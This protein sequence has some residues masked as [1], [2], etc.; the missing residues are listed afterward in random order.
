[1]SPFVKLADP[2][3]YVACPMDV[4]GDPAAREY[5]LPFF[6]SHF[7]LILGLAEE[8]LGPSHEIRRRMDEAAAAFDAKFDAFAENPQDFGRVTIMTLDGWRDAILR[9]FEFP[10]PFAAQ[11]ARENERSLAHLPAAV[12][13]V[14]AAAD[15]P[16]A[17]VEGV[18]AGNIFDMGAKETA[19]LYRDG[20]PNFDAVIER[21]PRRPWLAD[22]LDAL[23]P[24]LAA[25]GWKHC[26]YFVDNAG[27][28][29]VLG[30]VPFARHL[31]LNGCRVTL[32]ANE[33][34]SLN[35]ITIAE[36]RDLWPRLEQAEPSLRGLPIDLVSTGTGEPLIDLLEV[37]DE[38]NAAAEDADLVV[39]EGMGRGVESNYDARL[40]CDR[41]N[42]AMLKDDWIAGQVGGKLYDVVCRYAPAKP[43][44]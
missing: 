19:R 24:R 30:A 3:A 42:L 22:D 17:L 8:A 26:V 23:A 33:R 43:V 29:V 37:S 11:K 41:L 32:A 39:L 6:K 5:W 35:D 9:Q 36:L 38:L 34:P 7:R 25:G 28:D 40:T 16:R 44:L 14:E 12:R 15:G 1:M 18:F 4:A 20:G 13:R 2:S 31:A 21:L 27:S 10:D